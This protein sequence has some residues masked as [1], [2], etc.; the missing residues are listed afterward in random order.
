MWQARNNSPAFCIG[1]QPVFLPVS[2]PWANK[3]RAA[4]YRSHT[5]FHGWIRW[6]KRQYFCA[7][8]FNSVKKRIEEMKNE[9]FGNAEKLC[10][11]FVLLCMLQAKFIAVRIQKTIYGAYDNTTGLVVVAHALV[12]FIGVDDKIFIAH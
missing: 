3:L 7:T 10:G 4:D 1:K 12:A 5:G 9:F 8:F 6:K 11:R 2:F